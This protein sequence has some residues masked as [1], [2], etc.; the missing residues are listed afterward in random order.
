MAMAMVLVSPFAPLAK[1]FTLTIINHVVVCTIA[2]FD[3]GLFQT[4]RNAHAIAVEFVAMAGNRF[5]REYTFSWFWINGVHFIVIYHILQSQ[6][7]LVQRVWMMLIELEC[8]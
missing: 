8:V 6:K 3:L 4:L 7:Y 2:H 1:L 5:I